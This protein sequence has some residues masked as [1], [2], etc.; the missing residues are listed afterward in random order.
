MSRLPNAVKSLMMFATL[1]SINREIKSDR[2]PKVVLIDEGWSLLR[3]REAAS[4]ILEFVKTSRKFNTSMGFITQEIE[5]LMHSKTGRSILNTASVKILMR[6]NPTN[7]DLIGTALRLNDQAKN[8]LLTASSGYGLLVSEHNI[9]KF[10][11]RASDKLHELITTHPKDRSTTKPV[12]VK[13]VKKAPDVDLGKGIYLDSDMTDEQRIYLLA[14]EYHQHRSRLAQN[15]GS[16]KYLIKRRHNESADHAFLCWILQ[17][18][19]KRH[20]QNVQM[21]T[22]KPG[23]V[24]LTVD[25]KTIAFE[26]ETG[27][28]FRTYSDQ[29]HIKK[30]EAT[31]ERYDEIYIVLSNFNFRERYK[32]FGKVIT[33][34]Q[35]EPLIAELDRQYNRDSLTQQKQAN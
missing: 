29:E 25:G 24:V 35:I 34:N 21:Y 12:F 28:N 33:R 6:Q 10:F 18:K 31:R 15:G 9:Q 26:V 3:S 20:F 1:E 22:N 23:D 4:Y 14:N 17:D 27:Q 7:I 5:D 11:V 19:L 16:E 13:T 32:R 30:F 2:K 8:Y